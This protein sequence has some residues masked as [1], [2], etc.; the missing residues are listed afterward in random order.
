M[1]IGVAGGGTGDGANGGDGGRVASSGANT[2]Y[3]SGG[4]GATDSVSGGCRWRDANLGGRWCGGWR[5][6]L[7]G[8]SNGNGGPGAAE[9]V[10]S[11]VVVAVVAVLILPSVRPVVSLIP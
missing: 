8:G 1:L 2:Y 4:V 6:R 9:M 3:Q 10:I 5:I 11:A 7:G